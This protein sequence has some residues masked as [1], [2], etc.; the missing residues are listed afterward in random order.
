M[1]RI[2]NFKWAVKRNY[3]L[4]LMR[5][6]FFTF[7]ICLPINKRT[8]GLSYS[9][10][11]GWY[12]KQHVKWKD[13]NIKEDNLLSVKKETW[14]KHN[15][16]FVTRTG[17]TTKSKSH[18]DKFGWYKPTACGQFSLR[19]V[20]FA[21]CSEKMWEDSS[22]FCSCGGRASRVFSHQAMGL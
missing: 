10:Q 14:Y 9:G 7:K 11:R 22:G 8:S 18:Q 19:P 2:G 17:L 5:F 13:K 16:N 6:F 1:Q 3:S 12:Q 4:S 15:M 21:C 20:S